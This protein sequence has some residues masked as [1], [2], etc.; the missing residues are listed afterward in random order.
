VSVSASSTPAAREGARA[1]RARGRGLVHNRRMHRLA[2]AAIAAVA[3]AA[4]GCAT[5]R[6]RVDPS[7]PALV[8]PAPP[9]HAITPVEI[10]TE[11]P[12]P[13]ADAGPTPVV[14]Q[15]NPRSS[16]P[17][18]DRRADRPGDKTDAAP[19]VPAAP[20]TVNA[21]PPPLQTTANVTEL[22]RSVRA[23]MVQALR[24]LDRTNYRALS[25][26]R[27]TQYDTAKRFVQQAE[28]ALRVSNLVFA[29]QLADKAATLAAALAQK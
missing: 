9:I 1:V 5:G 8:P 17:R 12:A 29:G 6:A 3:L 11:A 15:P 16:A 14:V 18:P 23:R 10:E 21:A 13:P 19:A 28:D 27:R 24:D 20:P 25:A 2:C 4:C 26:D 22:E 7:G